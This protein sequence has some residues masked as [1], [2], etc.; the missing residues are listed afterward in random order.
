MHKSSSDVVTW[1]ALCPRGAW[2]KCFI[3]FWQNAVWGH[4]SW[5]SDL[6]VHLES[7]CHY[8]SCWD[9]DK[10]IH[11]EVSRT[12]L[13]QNDI[14]LGNA[15]MGHVC[16][17]RC[18]FKCATSSQW[19]TFSEFLLLECADCRICIRRSRWAST[20]F[21][22]RDDILLD[23]VTFICI[24]KTCAK[25]VAMKRG[26]KSMVRLQGRSWCKMKLCWPML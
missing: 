23:V 9:E 6:R 14:L 5:G 26:N 17:V 3:L 24:L 22:W 13:L 11:D 20:K 10:Q 4:P 18:Y 7:M 21:L 2:P 16:Q 12:G 25:I 19:A 8:W 15:L 1:I